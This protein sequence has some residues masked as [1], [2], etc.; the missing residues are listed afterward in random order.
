LNN[1]T[2]I[3][4]ATAQTLLVNGSGSYTVQ[5]S[6]GSC[7]GT[8]AATAVTVN[9]APATPVITASGPTTFCSGGSV[10]L[11]APTGFASY[12]WSNGSPISGATA[13]TFVATASGNYTVTVTNG[14]HGQSAAGRDDHGSCERLR[15]CHQQRERDGDLRRHVQLE[16]DERDDQRR[17]GNE[18]DYVHCGCDR[19]D[20]AQRQ[21]D[22]QWLQQQRQRERGGRGVHSD[23]DR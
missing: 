4:G 1:G 10:T 6:N 7:S 8:S 3:S 18:R 15:E 19:S 13:S 16:R 2:P 12:S 21:R 20:H 17:A 23:G 9:P 14:S 11:T 22:V 5:A